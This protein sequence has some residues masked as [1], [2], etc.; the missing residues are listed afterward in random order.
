M[1]DYASRMN[2]IN[3]HHS[4]KTKGWL[5]FVLLAVVVLVVIVGLLLRGHSKPPAPA[6]I[7]TPEAAKDVAAQQA[8]Q[9]DFYHVLDPSTAPKEA[10]KASPAQAVTAPAMNVPAYYAR[11]GTF[12]SKAAAEQSKANLILSGIST[13]LLLVNSENDHTYRVQMGPYQTKK[14]AQAQIDVLAKNHVNAQLVELNNQKD[15]Q[16]KG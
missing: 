11:L 3:D 7:V 9:F 14:L 5:R 10:A 13:D 4:S 15:M 16:T 12:K 1:R 8:V 6:P 2:Y